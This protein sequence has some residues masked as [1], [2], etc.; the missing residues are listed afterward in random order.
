M[1]TVPH[2]QI[3]EADDGFWVSAV[4][5]EGNTSSFRVYGGTYA[6]AEAKAREACRTTPDSDAFARATGWT[7]GVELDE[8]P[9]GADRIDREPQRSPQENPTMPNEN[10]TPHAAR[11][12]YL[13]A[14]AGGLWTRLTRAERETF[15]DGDLAAVRALAAKLGV[16]PKAQEPAKPKSARATEL[17]AI[18]AMT[19]AHGPLVAA[20]FVQALHAARTAPAPHA[21]VLDRAFGDPRRGPGTEARGSTVVFHTSGLP[22]QGSFGR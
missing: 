14:I 22:N 12:R 8:E 11:A 17:E 20:K 19:K 2:F 1:L 4:F 15:T 13:G 3:T 9:S 16:K 21:C 5:E 6:E 10:E 18:T 7:R